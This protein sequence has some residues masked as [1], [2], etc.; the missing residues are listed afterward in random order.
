MAAQLAAS[1]EGYNSDGLRAGRPGFDSRQRQ[2]IFLYA[3]VFRPALVLIGKPSFFNVRTTRNNR[4]T[5]S[6]IQRF[7]VFSSYL[8]GNTLRIRYKTQPVNA[9]SGN[10]HCLL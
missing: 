9:V 1:Q 7:S 5:L 2:E 8:T 6:R 3:I 4:Y 10:S